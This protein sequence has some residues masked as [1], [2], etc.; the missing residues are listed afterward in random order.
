MKAKDYYDK[1]RP[2]IYEVKDG[3]PHTL[4]NGKEA[5][6]PPT[7]EA[8]TKICNDII[9]DF[10]NESKEVAKRR[11]I[12]KSQALKGL[13]EEFNDKWNAF[14]RLFERDYGESPFAHNGFREVIF[15]IEPKYKSLYEKHTETAPDVQME[16]E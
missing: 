16:G 15:M 7:K 10:L 14:C 5:T 2:K 11:K 8:M 9:E 6:I 4:A 1:Y 12:C 3:L 13:I